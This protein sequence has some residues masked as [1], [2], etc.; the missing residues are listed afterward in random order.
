MKKSN[1][2]GFT[3][4]ELVIVIAV[5]AIL[6]AVLIPTF[7]SLV[8]KANLSSDMQAVREMNV[9]LKNDEVKNGKAENIT[10]AMQVV[11]N[12]GYD[13]KSWSPLTAGYQVYWYK[14]ENRCILY[15]SK[16]AKVEYPKDFEALSLA[17][18]KV[19]ENIYVY[20]QTFINATKVELNP[21]N[22]TENVTINGQE[23]NN[24]FTLESNSSNYTNLVIAENKETKKKA[25]NIKFAA[26]LENAGVAEKEKAAKAA[27]DFVRA[28]FTQMNIGLVPTDS[29]VVIDAG[30]VIDISGDDWKPVKLFTGYFGSSD[31]SKPVVID[32]LRLTSTTSYVDTY[33]LEGPAATYYFSGFIGAVYGKATIENITFKNVTI[34]T[35]ASDAKLLNPNARNNTCGIIGGVVATPENPEFD[36]TIKNVVVDNTCTV[37]GNS[38]A[39]GILGFIG[40]YMAAQSRDVVVNGET[41]QS[42]YFPAENSKVTLERCKFEGTVKSAF[43]K[44]PFATVGSMIGIAIRNKNTKITLTNCEATGKVIGTR[45]GGLIGELW[46]GVDVNI[47]NCKS[48]A[49]LEA[50]DCTSTS[51]GTIIGRVYE[52]EAQS[53][54]TPSSY[55]IDE[56]TL[57]NSGYTSGTEFTIVGVVDASLINSDINNTKNTYKI[58]AESKTVS[59]KWT[60]K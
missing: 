20:N 46:S 6:A 25:Y 18:P 47:T 22:G 58:G 7:S 33:S 17:D 8:K 41:I 42:A 35:P 60:I 27:G 39:G 43:D 4:V 14:T 2:K 56:A 55:T 28:I 30:T 54:Y 48:T 38:R 59:A 11:A 5:I 32:G 49:T 9:A 45:T 21:S 53:L 31:P 34:Q 57:S 24:G 44:S 23:Y 15:N 40:G 12:A 52:T 10:Q 1:K 26:A 50:V 37:I 13:V 19:A 3:I 29:D 36:V 16:E 51:K